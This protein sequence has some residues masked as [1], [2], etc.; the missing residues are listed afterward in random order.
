QGLIAIKNFE[1]NSSSR[2]IEVINANLPLDTSYIQERKKLLIEN[3]LR[4][5]GY[6]NTQICRRSVLIGYF[7][8]IPKYDFC[9][10]CDVCLKRKNL[11][12]ETAKIYPEEI[13][14]SVLTLVSNA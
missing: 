2:V 13:V 7:E 6:C 12:D 8:N 4:I 1:G 5:R 14:A 11:K 10:N 9:G 3:I